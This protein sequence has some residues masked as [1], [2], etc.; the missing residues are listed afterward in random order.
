MA[1]YAPG[2]ARGLDLLV[3]VRVRDSLLRGY[4]RLDLEMQDDFVLTGNMVWGLSNIDF[5]QWRGPPPNG[6]VYS[7]LCVDGSCGFAEPTEFT[8]WH[9]PCNWHPPY[10]PIAPW[11]CD[12]P[13]PVPRFADRNG[14]FWY[15]LDFRDCDEANNKQHVQLRTT[16]LDCRQ[17]PVRC[18]GGHLGVAHQ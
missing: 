2:V 8:Q 5:M 11:Q 12:P 17:A 14:V 1:C 9:I 6:A 4:L 15:R 7:P 16:V 3:P 10:I 13:R 18:N